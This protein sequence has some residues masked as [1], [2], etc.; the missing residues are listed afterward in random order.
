M[1]AADVA[2][3][4]KE[5]VEER[6]EYLEEDPEPYFYPSWQRDGARFCTVMVR[7]ACVLCAHSMMQ[8][9]VRQASTFSDL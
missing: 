6:P 2:S 1:Y 7:L 9:I 5:P 4:A 3:K 8:M